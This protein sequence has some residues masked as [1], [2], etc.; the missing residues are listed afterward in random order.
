[1]EQV[2]RRCFLPARLLESFWLR[3]GSRRLLLY[4]PPESGVNKT[5][6]CYV[7]V[8][9]VTRSQRAGEDKGRLER[10]SL[11]ASERQTP[12]G[13]VTQENKYAA[14]TF[15]KRR[16]PRAKGTF[17]DLPTGGALLTRT[18]AGPLLPLTPIPNLYSELFLVQN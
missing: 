13:R 11:Q 12:S 1:M 16:L 15:R 2:G 3:S 14:Q 9:L 6:L 17:G 18:T 8:L 4:A 5:R 10:K 7:I